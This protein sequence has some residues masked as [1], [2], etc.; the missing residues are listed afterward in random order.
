MAHRT[1]GAVR[2]AAER[3]PITFDFGLYGEET[4]IVRPDPS[5]GDTFDL[6]DAPEPAPGTQPDVALVQTLARFIRRMLVPEDRPRF[7][8]TLYR[9]PSTEAHLILEA[10]TFIAEQVTGFPTAPSTSSSGGRRANG[11]T[12]RQPSAGRARS[13][14]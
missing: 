13:K 12:S 6:L 1:F 5:L 14:R 9:I 4:F 3:E 8:Q 7:D 2:T 11:T 10:A